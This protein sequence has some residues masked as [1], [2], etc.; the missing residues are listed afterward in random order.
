MYKKGVRLYTGFGFL[1]KLN[2]AAYPPRANNTQELLSKMNSNE[3]E[4]NKT[5]KDGKDLER[6]KTRIH[7]AKQHYKLVH[8]K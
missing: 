3:L 8:F 6:N 2:S 4:N 5:Q 7:K 1:P